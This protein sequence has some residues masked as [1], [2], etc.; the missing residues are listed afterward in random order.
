MFNNKY[1][2]LVIPDEVYTLHCLAYANQLLR[3]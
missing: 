3:L 2:D 1:A